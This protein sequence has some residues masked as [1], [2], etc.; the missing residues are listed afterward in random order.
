MTDIL[1][2]LSAT[3]LAKAN[4]E[5]LYAFHPFSHGWPNMDKY[6][7]KELSWC[8]TDVAFAPCNAIFRARLA[9]EQVDKTIEYLT[10]KARRRNVPLSWII[11]KDSQPA[12]L[13]KYLTAHGFTTFGDSAGMA[14]D[15]LEMKEDRPQPDDLKIIEVKDSDTLKTWCLV[16]RTG[17]G[18]PQRGD[19]DSMY[20]WLTKDI[21]YKQPIRFYLASLDGKPVATSMVYFGAGV[22]GIYF[23]TTLPETRKRGIGFAITLKPLKL[24]REMGYRAGT[25]QA[26]KLGEPIYRRMGFKEYCRISN[27][28]WIPKPK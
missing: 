5:N 6:Q 20:E 25:L 4:E 10:A 28:M 23:V 18:I 17:F 8:I 3:A 22:A 11:T 16:A 19:R 9:P 15:L 7:S 14:I 1:T 27:Y 26:S 24:A 13:G 21:E 2:D 12:D